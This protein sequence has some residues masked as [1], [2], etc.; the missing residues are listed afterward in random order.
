MPNPISSKACLLWVLL[1]RDPGACSVVEL[2]LGF[3]SI[4]RLCCCQQLPGMVD[5]W[6][7][8]GRR[9]VRSPGQP[10]GGWQGLSCSPP[11]LLCLCNKDS[12]KRHD[13]ILRLLFVL[14]ITKSISLWTWNPIRK[15]VRVCV[16]ASGKSVIGKGRSWL[17]LVT[18]RAGWRA[19]ASFL[20]NPYHFQPMKSFTSPPLSLPPP[21]PFF[22]F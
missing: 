11:D 5:Q 15:T 6:G 21:P 3:W 13:C 20:H 1:S 22:L 8:Q 12:D 14:K 10:E 18:S 7:V 2:H 9:A 19:S 17:S 16:L 4:F